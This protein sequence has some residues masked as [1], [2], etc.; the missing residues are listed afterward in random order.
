MNKLI[1]PLL[2]F[3][4]LGFAQTKPK[5]V[6]PPPKPVENSEDRDFT[7]QEK[8]EL[9]TLISNITNAQLTVNNAQDA[10]DEAKANLINAKKNLTTAQSTL[11]K[12]VQQ[13][14]ADHKD[15][16]VC[17][18]PGQEPCDDVIEGDISLRS[19]TKKK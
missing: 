11:N 6:P 19:S 2:L 14:Y 18:G 3:A 7:Y 13:I 1:I 9:R 16:V 10:V 15:K 17:I 4:S 8:F 12:K 5:S